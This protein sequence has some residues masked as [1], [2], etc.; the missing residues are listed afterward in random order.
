MERPR[1]ALGGSPRFAWRA[2]SQALGLLEI[3]WNVAYAPGR[4]LLGVVTLNID[5]AQATP[6]HSR[7]FFVDKSSSTRAPRCEGRARAMMTVNYLVNRMADRLSWDLQRLQPIDWQPV[8]RGGFAADITPLDALRM[9]CD[10]GLVFDRS[11]R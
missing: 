9:S 11:A 5:L 6:N 1:R 2:L 10:R 7:D 8:G 3:T 4:E